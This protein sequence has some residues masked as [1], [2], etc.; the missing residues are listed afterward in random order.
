MDCKRL[1]QWCQRGIL[2]LVLAILVYAPLALG[3]VRLSEF[4]VLM[5][6]VLGVILLWA[7]R[8]WL[9]P[10]YRLLWPPICW[11]VLFFVLYAIGRYQFAEIEYVARQELLRVLVYA[12][13]FFVIVNHLH[14]KESTR[15]VTLTLISLGMV[16]AMYAVYQT[17]ANSQ[18]VWHFPKPAV[19]G[20]RGSGTFICPNSLA[21]YLE[22]LVPLGLAYVFT[23]RFKNLTKVLLGYATLV[24]LAGIGVSISRGGWVATGVALTVFFVWMLRHREYRISAIVLLALLVSAGCYFYLHSF[25]AQKRLA[26][27]IGPGTFEDMRFRIWRAAYRMWQEHFWWGVG[28]GHFDQ[29][30]REYRLEANTAPY[31]QVRPE[32]V[33]NDYLNTLTDWGLVGALLVAA[34]WVLLY[35]GVYRNWKHFRRTP[36]DL[37]GKPSNRSAVV[38]GASVGLL[39]ILVH[40]ATDFNMHIPANAILA[41]TL[42]AI[43]T[44][45]YRYAT[46]RYWMKPGQLGKA[47]MTVILLIGFCYLAQHGWREAVEGRWLARAKQQEKLAQERLAALQ[48]TLAL[49]PTDSERTDLAGEVLR[50]RNQYEELLRE[51]LAALQKAHA[52]E[53]TNF[54]TT[55]AIGEALRLRSWQGNE[56]Y[57]MWARL[58]MDWFVRSW[59][60]NPYDGYNYLRYGMC[61]H[62]LGRHGAAIPYFQR[63]DRLDP[64]SYYMAAHLGWHYVQLGDYGTAR[65]WFERSLNLQSKDNPIASAYMEIVNNKLAEPPEVNK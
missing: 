39:A 30:F 8:L 57:R 10:H 4:V 33:H 44:G 51:R 22:M 36:A 48:K 3:A 35:V 42:M 60:L 12:F 45:H 59:E 58:A 29:R 7:L 20:I 54:E 56:D 18:R 2:G 65:K 9:D 11:A 16:I 37:G 61:L 63:A 50:L 34:P 38:L 6:L 31:L 19:Y 53:P 26:D 47:L 13:I 1:D 62:W 40:S 32:L 21:G 49:E 14:D 17:L 15:V 25:Q 28:P 52:V 41:V 55:Y 64:N 27:Q 46:E 43:I 24:M 5:G 23:G